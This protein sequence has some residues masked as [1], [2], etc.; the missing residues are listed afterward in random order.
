[1]LYRFRSTC[2][3]WAKR[4]RTR[5]ALLAT[6]WLAG[7]NVISQPIGHVITAGG[8]GAAGYVEGVQGVSEFNAPSAL[9]F[10]DENTL[11]IADRNNDIVRSMRLT[12]SQTFPFAKVRRPVGLAFDSKT[13]LFVASQFDGTIVKFDY[14]RNARATNK[15]ALS[16]GTITAL[17]IDRDDNLYIAQQG[18]VVTK[19]DAKGVLQSELRAPVPGIHE[20]QSRFS[21]AIP[22]IRRPP[23]MPW[24]RA[25]RGPAGR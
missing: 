22:R 24:Q 4:W 25:P 16:G 2:L 9:A 12:D 14:Y 17:A 15:P 19:L 18:G 23:S 7:Q 6:A 20:F 13:N 3:R 21:E 5:C 1:M 8:T 11:F 10:R